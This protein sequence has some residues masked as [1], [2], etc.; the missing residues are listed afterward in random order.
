MTTASFD[1]TILVT[2][3]TGL[4]GHAIQFIVKN[5]SIHGKKNNE[6][7]IFLASKD[8]DLRLVDGSIVLICVYGIGYI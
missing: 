6:K 7:W 4:I 3:G 8:G 5:D 1:M 2:G